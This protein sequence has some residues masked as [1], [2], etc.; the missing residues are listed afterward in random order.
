MGITDK[1]GN[2]VAAGTMIENIDLCDTCAKV[3]I[4]NIIDM[5][6]RGDMKDAAAGQTTEEIAAGQQAEENGNRQQG[7]NTYQCS[8]VMKTCAYAEKVGA[9]AT[10]CN[11]I[12]IEGHRRGCEPEKCDK[13]KKAEKK[14]GRKPKAQNPPADV[15]IEAE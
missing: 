4:D 9:A 13:Y 6:E 1:N 10:M 15:A 5:I 3:I 7:Q 14:R 8:K 12:G 2:D 11:Y